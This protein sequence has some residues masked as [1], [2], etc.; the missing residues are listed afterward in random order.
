MSP[1][2]ELCEYCEMPLDDCMCYWHSAYHGWTD[3]KTNKARA[4][5]AGKA[6]PETA[7]RA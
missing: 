2:S 7:T 4:D 5:K 3:T 1:A 6:K